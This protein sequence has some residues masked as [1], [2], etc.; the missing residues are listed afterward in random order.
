MPLD[1]R[2]DA[3]KRELPDKVQGA[4]ES[5]ETMDEPQDGDARDA[6]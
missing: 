3:T 1:T 6:L 5:E 4:G 2:P